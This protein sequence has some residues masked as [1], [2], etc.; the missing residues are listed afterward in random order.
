[1]IKIINTRRNK[2]TERFEKVVEWEKEPNYSGI[3][4]GIVSTIA[5]LSFIVLYNIKTLFASFSCGVLLGIGTIMI[6]HHLGE[7]K[8]VYWRKIK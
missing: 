4:I 6:I 2:T 7:G 5:S 8:K 3:S 1:M